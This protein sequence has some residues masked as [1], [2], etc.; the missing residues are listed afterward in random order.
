[1]DYIEGIFQTTDT[2]M[3]SCD[4][5]YSCKRDRNITVYTSRGITVKES[6]YAFLLEV[7]VRP[8]KHD[9]LSFKWYKNGMYVVDSDDSILCI[10]LQDIVSEGEYKCVCSIGYKKMS[11]NATSDDDE[12]ADIREFIIATSKGGRK[13]TSDIIVIHV[14]TLLCKYKTQLSDRYRSQPQVQVEE[15]AWP[16]RPP[17]L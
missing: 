9:S 15:H 12:P 13:I 11:F 6:E 8:H 1:M 10:R 4:K 16:E 5:S 7:I 2:S 3:M 17:L 14:E